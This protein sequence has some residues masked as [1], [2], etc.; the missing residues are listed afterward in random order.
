MSIDKSLKIT[1]SLVRQRNVLSRAERIAALR[2]K[3]AWDEE[4]NSLYGLPKVRVFRAKRR[5]KTEEKKAE[6]EV[7]AEVAAPEEEEKTAAQTKTKR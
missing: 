7:G 4:K 6:V 3:N 5:I 1:N 2:D